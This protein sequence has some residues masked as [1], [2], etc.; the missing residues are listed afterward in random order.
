[1]HRKLLVALVAALMV[2]GCASLVGTSQAATGQTIFGTAT[3]GINTDPD[4]SRTVVGT[5]FRVAKAGTVDA[6]KVHRSSVV[7]GALTGKVARGSTVLATVTLPA[8]G[9]GWQVVDLPA[10]VSVATGQTYTVYYT[11]PAGRYS[12]KSQYT[13][14]KVSG[15]LTAVKGVYTFGSGVPTSVYQN[16]NYFVDV[17]FNP[18]S[19]VSPTTTSAEPTTSASPTS[20]QSTPPVTSE[21]TTPATTT[22]AT[23][24][25]TTTPSSGG[26]VVLGRSFPDASTTGVPDDIRPSLTAYT[27]P[28]TLSD[29][30]A[31]PVT[32]DRKVITCDQFRLL[33]PK[34]TITNSIINGTVFSDCC[35]LNGSFSITDSEVRGPNSTATVVGEARFK[36]LRVEVTG[37]SRSVNCNI[38]CDVRDSY[39]HG[40]YT[41]QR[42]IDHESGIRQDG[43]GTIIH[44]TISCDAKPVEPDAG[45]SAAISGYGDFG[46]VNNNTIRDNLISVPDQAASFCMYGGSTRGKPYPNA[47]DIKVIDNIFRR[48]ESGICGIWGPVADFDVNAP[49]NVWQNNVFDD[50]VQIP[51]IM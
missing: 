32:I 3:S 27:G 40:Q 37:G 29:P 23:I 39:I 22:T 31:A 20:E 36:L 5:Q 10:P 8:A 1:M 28:C 51:G 49:G 11:A 46:T 26:V 16:E 14:P 43:H 19:V 12:V 6:I 24:S 34:V 17:V 15:D 35:Y 41:D 9:P 25:T 50:G 42:G 13:W 45:C 38:E 30:N 44:N 4:T 18:A 33:Q 7:S 2:V 48:G 47:H 21:P